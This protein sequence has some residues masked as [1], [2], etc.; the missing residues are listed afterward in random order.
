MWNHIEGTVNWTAVG[1]AFVSGL[2]DNPL[3]S[4]AQLAATIYIIIKIVEYFKTG[5]LS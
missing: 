5:R 3:A 1:T 4:I 2:F